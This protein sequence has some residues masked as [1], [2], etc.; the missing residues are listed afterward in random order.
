[1][2]KG[3]DVLGLMLQ[4]GWVMW[5]LLLFSVAAMAV[6]GE[7][8]WALRRCRIDLPRFLRRLERT[9]A[10]ERSVQRAQALCAEVRGPVAAVVWAGLA[11]FGQPVE[12]LALA[13][14][15]AARRELRRLERGF[16]VVASTANVAPLCGFLGTVTGMIA[17]FGVLA[18]AGLQR[19]DLVAAGIEE[20]LLTTAAGLVV[21]IP[22]QL[23]HTL[24][25]GRL[26]RIAGDIEV[27][28]GRLVELA[29]ER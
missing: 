7:R 5:V 12:H 28:A 29:G 21:A 2:P 26:E 23:A 17:S 11:S 3:T 25:R 27:A 14:E 22:A 13:M 15:A 10:G 6:T 24:L 9:L 8:L 16:V 1:M 18:E 4:G 20:A 19:P